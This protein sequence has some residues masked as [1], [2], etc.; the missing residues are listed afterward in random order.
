MPDQAST[1]P[2]VNSANIPP[3]GC[4]VCGGEA[5]NRILFSDLPED[6]QPIVKANISPPTP[7]ATICRHCVQLFQRAKRQIDSHAAVFEQTSY[8]LPTPWRMEA[9]ERFTGRG[10]TI[11]FLDSGFYAHA[12]LV[13]PKNRIVAYHNIFAPHEDVVA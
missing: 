1:S 11:A 10:V 3:D 12:D 5:E 8:V 6:L 9:D 7:A 2:T 13:Q 4:N